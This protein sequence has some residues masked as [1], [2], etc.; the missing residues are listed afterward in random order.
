[1]EAVVKKLMMLG[2]MLAMVLAAAAPALAQENG[3]D[4]EVSN[5]AYL[6]CVQI[7]QQIGGDQYASATG[8]GEG[9]TAAANNQEFSASQI[10]QCQVIVGQYNAG[11]QNAGDVTV[12][13]PD[14]PAPGDN[15]GDN[16]GNGDDNGGD[17]NGGGNGD[18]GNGGTNGGGSNGGGTSNGGGFDGG[19][20]GGGIAVLPDT[21]GVPLT[22]LLAGVALISCGLV[23]RRLV[24]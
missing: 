18:G 9:D 5:E 20:G 21:G 4:G 13:T 10:Q 1:M 11:G 23:A 8:S 6:R 22:G 3:D 19:S 7:L 12:P 2:A 17:G 16:G 15:G 14:A 24:R